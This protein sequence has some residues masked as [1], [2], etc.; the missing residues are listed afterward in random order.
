[1]AD[2]TDDLRAT[3]DDITADAERL[4]AIEERKRALGS[5][6]PE[7]IALS[8]EAE[9]IAA[10]LPSKTRTQRELVVEQAEDAAA[11]ADPP[12]PGGPEAGAVR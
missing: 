1:M 12:T 3:I 6:D 10:D 2:E 11:E 7:R 8:E 4:K 5:D 9:H